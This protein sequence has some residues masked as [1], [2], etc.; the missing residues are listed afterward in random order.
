[1]SVDDESHNPMVE[2]LL[3]HH[4]TEMIDALISDATAAV[5]APIEEQLVAILTPEEW[6][7]LAEAKPEESEKFLAEKLH[8]PE[9]G[10]IAALYLEV[11]LSSTFLIDAISKGKDR[12][13]W[14]DLLSMQLQAIGVDGA[15][16]AAQQV[17]NFER[18][19]DKHLGIGRA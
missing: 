3:A 4:G 13:P 15:T 1:M 8:D 17:R 9:A 16:T 10:G 18:V 6:E 5:V 12:Q 7:H 19:V 11:K 14:R 2:Y